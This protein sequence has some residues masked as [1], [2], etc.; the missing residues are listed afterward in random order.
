MFRPSGA[1][2]PLGSG[3]QNCERTAAECDRTSQKNDQLLMLPTSRGCKTLSAL[4]SGPDLSRPPTVP[5]IGAVFFPKR[6]SDLGDLLTRRVSLPRAASAGLQMTCCSAGRMF[7][8][9]SFQRRPSQIGCLGA[10]RGSKP[11]GKVVP[12]DI[13]GN[14]DGLAAARE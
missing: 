7:A 1:H 8:V 2:T 4:R 5:E 13:E 12:I 11:V 14:A 9:A 10:P 6:G 3:L